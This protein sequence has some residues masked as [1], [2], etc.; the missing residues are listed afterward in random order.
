MKRVKILYE[1]LVEDDQLKSEEDL[2][3]EGYIDYEEA[4]SIGG[5]DEIIDGSFEYTMN[6]FVFD[7]DE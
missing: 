1:A 5:I 6:V 3:S 2:Q 7:E 4:V